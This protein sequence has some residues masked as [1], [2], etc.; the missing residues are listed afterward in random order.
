MPVFPPLLVSR[1]PRELG[2]DWTGAR[3]HFGGAPRLSSS[4]WPRDDKREPLHFVAQLDL[5]EL[6]A[7]TGATPLPD[8]GSLAFFIGEAGGVTEGAVIFVPAGQGT[9]L[10]LPPADMPELDKYGGSSEWLTDLEG[11]RLFPF[12]PVDFSM[13]DIGSLTASF[14]NSKAYCAAT[15]A[16]VERHHP[17]RQYD[18]SPEAAFAGPQIPD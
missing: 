2:V 12:W 13:L 6:A 4:P 1:R 18:I 3:S 5:A 7:K 17:R 10:V 9:T 8:T 15:I 14:E 16:A 11:R